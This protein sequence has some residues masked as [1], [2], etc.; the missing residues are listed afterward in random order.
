MPRSSRWYTQGKLGAEVRAPPHLGLGD[1]ARSLLSGGESG[2]PS[3]AV[4]RWTSWQELLTRERNGFSELR[5]SKIIILLHAFLYD[6]VDL[7][8]RDGNSDPV[9]SKFLHGQ[10]STLVP[11]LSSR[12]SWVEIGCLQKAMETLCACPRVWERPGSFNFAGRAE[13]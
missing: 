6:I 2:T 11:T 5:W 8:Q 13:G 4:S 3:L 1:N 9:E 12:E 10:K 7:V